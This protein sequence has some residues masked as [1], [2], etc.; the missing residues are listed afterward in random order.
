MAGGI[1]DGLQSFGNGLGGILSGF[2][3][4]LNAAWDN[5]GFAGGIALLGARRGE[6]DKAIQNM[7]ATMM[8]QRMFQSQRDDKKK[9][10]ERDARDFAFR[11]AEANRAQTNADRSHE[12]A[13]INSEKPQIVGSDQTGYFVVRPSDY[14]QG[15]ARAGAAPQP[16]PAGGQPRPA[17]P[18]PSPT[19]QPVAPAPGQPAPAGGL[20]PIIPAAPRASTLTREQEKEY[21]GRVKRF[22]EAGDAARGMID[23][24]AQIRGLREGVS[25]EG[26]WF[27]GPRTTIGQALDLKSGG[28]GIPSGTE[29]GNAAALRSKAVDM[30]LG[31]SEKTKG[32]ITDREQA[33][34]ASAT[35]G[36]SMADTGAAIVLDAQEAAAQRVIERSKFYQEYLRAHRSLAGADDA[37]DGY[38]TANPIITMQGGK[39][40][41]NKGNVGNWR[42]YVGGE[43]Q[44]GAQPQRTPE[45]EAP[46]AAAT[47]DALVR[48]RDAIKRGADPAAVRQRLMDAGINPAGL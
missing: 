11:Q 17:M 37:W 20:Q 22:N 16:I 33:M 6:E 10:D 5:P 14:I 48:A 21:A 32:A 38:R 39:M 44:A 9:A 23:D 41:V 35:P 19:P 43:P 26:G 45:Q 24:V 12:L 2:G 31:F 30:Q 18:A 1:L 27:A 46:Q 8:A 36:L 28:F 42:S 4:R 3:D 13:R 25:Y 15:G 47:S 7:L 34:F 40:I 29:A